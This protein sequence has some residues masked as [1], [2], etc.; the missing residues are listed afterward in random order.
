M[1]PEA[2]SG[3]LLEVLRDRLRLPVP[4]Q[5]A[6]ETSLR[7]LGVDS[8]GLLELALELEDRLGLPLPDGV[9]LR[10]TLGELCRQ[11]VSASAGRTAGGSP[12]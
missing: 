5:V 1:E 10:T 11:L 2:V 9:T 12:T 7:A 4:R 8:L 3:A 6:E